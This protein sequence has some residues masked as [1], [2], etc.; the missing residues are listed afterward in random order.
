M[1]VLIV[2]QQIKFDVATGTVM[3]RFEGI[4]KAS[5]FGELRFLLGPNSTAFEPERAVGELHLGLKNFSD[6][7]F[8]LLVGNP[9]LIGLAT[10]IAANYNNGKVK[11]LQWSG[12]ESN[13]SEIFV[14]IF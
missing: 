8:L 5:K 6:Q 9:I 7:D 10:S 13:Y 1:T 3:P 4:E 12:R 2:Q 11:F 14:R